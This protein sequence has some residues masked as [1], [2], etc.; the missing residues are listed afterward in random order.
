MRLALHTDIDS[1]DSKI[2]SVDPNIGSAQIPT[3]LAIRETSI[4]YRHS[5][6]RVRV[7]SI[8]AHDPLTRHMAP[9]APRNGFQRSE[10]EPTPLGTTIPQRQNIIPQLDRYHSPGD[11][12]CGSKVR[13]SSEPG[14][15]SPGARGACRGRAGIDRPTWVVQ[16]PA[17]ERVTSRVVLGEGDQKV[18]CNSKR[19]SLI[20]RRALSL[21][22]ARVTTL[23][24]AA[25]SGRN[26]FPGV[27]V[28]LRTGRAHN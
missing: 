27:R 3:R 9:P 6:I 7:P 25:R 23:T 28:L 11:S 1:D 15:R 2:G 18:A 19:A 22:R 26:S 20:V 4:A 8:A 5:P 16:L 17:G 14:H 24:R 10:H 12:S 13:P 21:A